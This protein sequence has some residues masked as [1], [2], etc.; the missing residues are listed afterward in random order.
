[1]LTPLPGSTGHRQIEAGGEWMEFE[2]NRFDS[3]HPTVRHPRMSA[4]EWLN[5]YREAWRDFYSVD[6][7]KGV[8]ARAR[9]RSYWSLFKNFVWYRHS[10]VIE[11]T[12]SMLCGFFRRKD[13][14]DRREGCTEDRGL[15]GDARSRAAPRELRELEVALA[16][17]SRQRRGARNARR[18]DF[19]PQAR[20]GACGS[21][22]GVAARRGDARPVLASGP[23]RGRT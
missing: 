8:L 6:A 17:S 9:E 18:A 20:R 4:G 16:R 22:G 12:Y 14:K 11:G 13:R 7:M 19:M 23:G 21:R 3:F 1:M 10:A 5:V 2:I 15:A